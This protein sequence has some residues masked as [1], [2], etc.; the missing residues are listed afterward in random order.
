MGIPFVTR[1]QFE[2][3]G[4]HPPTDFTMRCRVRAYDAADALLEGTR[5]LRS[6][7]EGVYQWEFREEDWGFHV[8]RTCPG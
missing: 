4:F 1:R 7:L 8:R 5:R 3:V 6:V 2:V